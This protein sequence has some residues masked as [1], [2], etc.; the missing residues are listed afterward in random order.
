MPA[1]GHP[2]LAAPGCGPD[3][4]AGTAPDDAAP[5]SPS[6]AVGQRSLTAV[7]ETLTINMPPF[8]PTTS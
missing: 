4:A 3:T 5:G 7:P 8:W 1:P 6:A 2:G